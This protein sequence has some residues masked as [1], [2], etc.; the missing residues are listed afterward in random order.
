M[1]RGI[2]SQFN[3]PN[4]HAT[5]HLFPILI[6]IRYLIGFNLITTGICNQENLA[7]QIGK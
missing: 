6:K 1:N 2:L 4:F 5:V 3:T 7:E